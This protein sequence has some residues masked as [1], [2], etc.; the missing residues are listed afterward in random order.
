MDYP[1]DAHDTKLGKFEGEDVEIKLPEGY[2]ASKLMWLAV[3]CRRFSVNFGDVMFKTDSG[4]NRRASG[5]HCHGMDFPEILVM[6][7][8]AILIRFKLQCAN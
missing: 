8:I 6:V 5:G 4:D 7:L 1:A 2:E 3:W